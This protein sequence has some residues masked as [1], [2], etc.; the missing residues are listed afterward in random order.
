MKAADIY[1]LKAKDDY[2]CYMDDAL[3][4]LNYGLSYDDTHAGLLTLRGEI[5]YKDLRQFADAAESFGLALFHDPDYTETYYLYIDLL[6]TVGDISSAEKLIARALTVTGI[7]KGRVWHNEALLY[8]QQGIY[9]L[10]LDS[11]RSAILWCTDED[12]S[13]LYTKEKKRIKKKMNM[14]KKEKPETVGE[15]T[16]VKA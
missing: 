8:E 15:T 6:R 1:F 13:E 3:E 11:L 5:Q 16:E 4:A 10:A 9:T 12:D 14:L 2:P 7:D